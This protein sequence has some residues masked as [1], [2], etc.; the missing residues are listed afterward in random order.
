MTTSIFSENERA[1]YAWYKRISGHQW[2][3][4][5]AA[6]MGYLLDGFDFVLITLVLTE[7]INDFN[8]SLVQ[9][10][11][12]VSAAFVSRWFGGL[13][14]GAISDIYGRKPGMIVSITLYSLGSLGCAVA[15]NYWALFAARLAI[16]LGM[17]GEYSA[18]SLYVIES[19]PESVRNK[20]SG[21]L[22][23]GYSI[24]VVAAGQVYHF[25]VPDYGWRAIFF[26]GLI[27][28]AITFWLRRG[29]H[30]SGD[31]SRQNEQT[32]SAKNLDMFRVLFVDKFRTLNI[33]SAL[34]AFACLIV[35]FTY[36]SDSRVLMVAASLIVAAVFVSY[37]VQFAGPRWPCNLL[38]LIV[39]FTAF[40]YSW[41]IQSLLP[42]YLKTQLG[43]DAGQVSD[44]IFFSGFGAAAGCILAG[45]TGDY[46]GTRRAYWGSLLVSQFLIFPVFLVG[47]THLLVLGGLL[48]VQQM[49]GQGIAGLLP[50]WISG[51]FVVAKRASGLGFI[52]NVGALGGAVAPILGAS[53]SATMPL[54]TA[55]AVISFTLT[56]VV[57]IL[58]GFNIPAIAQRML[59]PQ[60]LRD[61]DIKDSLPSDFLE[62]S[63]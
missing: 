10:S 53:V 45:F 21:F 6:W 13:A 33:T 46:F 34:T 36:L 26:V 48:F 25:I 43:Y 31:W 37:L 8:L 32:K 52:Y 56:F 63:K 1:S 47:G 27:P 17:A 20:A 50:K 4:F 5:W 29:L 55:L 40:L 28:I 58:V 57:I 41:P 30:E 19:W 49:L 22:I 54:G 15:P 24:G 44:V 35:I 18:S 60:S 23:S 16:G 42:T 39:V 38:V 3:A 9:G 62:S 14:I 51:Y 2:K 61:T 59:H 11:S 12:L 7:I